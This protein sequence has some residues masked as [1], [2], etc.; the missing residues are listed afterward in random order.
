M[1]IYN[2]M[3][4]AD[5]IAAGVPES[6][7]ELWSSDEYAEKYFAELKKRWELKDFLVIKEKK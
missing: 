7:L 2:P 4:H 1:K 3:T 5:A 6:W